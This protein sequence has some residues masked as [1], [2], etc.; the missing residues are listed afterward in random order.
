MDVLVI[1]FETYY[2]KQYGFNKLTTEEYV[3][4]DRFE[5][6]GVAVKRNNE[7][8]VWFSGTVKKTQDFLDTFDWYNSVAVAHNAKFDM[9]VLNWLFGIRP[10]KIADTRGTEDLFILTARPQTAAGPI[11]AFMKALGIDIP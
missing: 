10:K 7:P 1:D 3:R 4:D 6:I 2:D 5:V 8:T 9:A 11:K